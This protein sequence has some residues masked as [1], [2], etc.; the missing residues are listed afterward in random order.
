M[1][2]SEVKLFFVP[3]ASGSNVTL[4][5]FEF[6]VKNGFGNNDNDADIYSLAGTTS[7][8]LFNTGDKLKNDLKVTVDAGNRVLTTSQK[9]RVSTNFDKSFAGDPSSACELSLN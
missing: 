8:K 6:L 4:K 2:R 3:A 5:R 1:L 9:V 7:T